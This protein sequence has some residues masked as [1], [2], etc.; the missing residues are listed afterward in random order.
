MSLPGYTLSSSSGLQRIYAS[1]KRADIKRIKLPARD[2]LM[3]N[4]VRLA[5]YRQRRQQARKPADLGAQYF[6]T[7]CDADEFRL[8]AMGMVH[9]AH[10]GARIRNLLVT[11]SAPE[12]G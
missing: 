3:E 8:S 12:A 7:R 1:V 9:C 4:I 11:P 10:C 2:S 6:C 5:E